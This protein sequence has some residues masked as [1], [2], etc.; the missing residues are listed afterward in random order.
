[1]AV[2]NGVL[3]IFIWT[4]H[5]DAANQFFTEIKDLLPNSAILHIGTMEKPGLAG[6]NGSTSRKEDAERIVEAITKELERA[7]GIRLL[8]EWE[9]LIHEAVTATTENLIEVVR[10]DRRND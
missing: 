10:K 4:K 8:W 5:I 2:D 7:I 9:Q 6:Q 1:V 3:A